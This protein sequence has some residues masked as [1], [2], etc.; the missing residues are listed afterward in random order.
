[1]FRERERDRE[2]KNTYGRRLLLCVKWVR[3]NLT[4][5]YSFKLGYQR[6]CHISKTNHDQFQTWRV[7]RQTMEEVDVS[8]IYPRPW[9]NG[10]I[11]L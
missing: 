4:N 7:T 9:E 6:G 11:M 10:K 5:V 8:E 2:N 3:G 1:M